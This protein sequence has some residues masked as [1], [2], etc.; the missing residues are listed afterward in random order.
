MPKSSDDSKHMKKVKLETIFVPCED[1]K[2]KLKFL[3]TKM[4]ITQVELAEKTGLS[5]STITRME[6]RG[7]IPAMSQF[8]L[9]CEALGVMVDLKVKNKYDRSPRHRFDTDFL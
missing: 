8:L 3:R 4:E 5:L 6:R 9:V 7:Y 2:V 1:I